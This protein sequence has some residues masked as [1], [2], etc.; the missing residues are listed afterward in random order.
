[1]VAVYP[2]VRDNPRPEQ[3]GE[4]LPRG[5]EGFHRFGGDLDYVSGAGYLGSE[6]FSFMVPLLL[7]V[8]AIGAGARAI[9]GEEER[10][11]LDLLLANPLSR[12]LL[13]SRSWRRSRPRSCCSRSCSGSHCWSASRSSDDVSRPH[14]APRPRARRCSPSPSAR[15]RSV[16]RGERTPGGGDRRDGGGRG[17][18]VSR[19]L[20]RR[21]RRLARA[22]GRLALLP[23]PRLRPP[24][25]RPCS[26]VMS[27][28]SLRSR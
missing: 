17:R 8:A 19:Q 16:R 28:F 12:A 22:V 7:L 25:P 6:L 11:T 18:R 13:V 4:R 3:D 20:A 21:A 27:P 15:S 10:G 23:L 24:A 26:S 14:L 1:M 9:A 5:A 2:T